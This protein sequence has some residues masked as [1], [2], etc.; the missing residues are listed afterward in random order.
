MPLTSS[1]RKPA[2]GDAYITKLCSLKLYFPLYLLPLVVESRLKVVAPMS[3][4]HL[5]YIF[6]IFFASYI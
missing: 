2:Q 1:T 6:P 5:Y 4:I 3:G